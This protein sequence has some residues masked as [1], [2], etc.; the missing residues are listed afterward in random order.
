[1]L[2]TRSPLT[3]RV[4][5][6]KLEAISQSPIAGPFDLHVSGTPPAF[7]L[8][9]DQTL[10]KA[11]TQTSEPLTLQASCHSSIVKVRQL[12][13]YHNSIKMSNKPMMQFSATLYS[14]AYIFQLVKYQNP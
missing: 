11:F 7:I 8:S 1:M 12:I 13:V 4:L 9:Q 3:N 5:G 2:L 14:I 6:C 10:H